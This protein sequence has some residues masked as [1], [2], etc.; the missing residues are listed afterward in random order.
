L[1][2]SPDTCQPS[3]FNIS[4]AALPTIPLAPTTNARF[5]TVTPG[6][7]LISFWM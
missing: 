3:L 6:R 5:N 7:I 4:A 1:R 2:A